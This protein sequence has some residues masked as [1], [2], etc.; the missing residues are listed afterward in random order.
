MLVFLRIRAPGRVTTKVQGQEQ[1]TVETGVGTD[2]DCVCLVRTGRWKGRIL[3]AHLKAVMS[4]TRSSFSVK[5]I[6]RPPTNVDK[7][8]PAKVLLALFHFWEA[9]DTVSPRFPFL[10]SPIS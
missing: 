10:T 6:K 9:T 7:C 1:Q 4:S 8:D 5:W 3:R 2:D